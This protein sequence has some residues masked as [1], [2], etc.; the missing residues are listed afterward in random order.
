MLRLGILVGCLACSACGAKTGL[1]APPPRDAGD[2]SDDP[3]ADPPSEADAEAGPLCV[4][5]TLSFAR[6][7]D[8]AVVFV[9][10]ASGSMAE[11][12]G[13]AGSKW[14]AA[15]D[16]I[17][18]LVARFAAGVRFGLMIFPDSVGFNACAP[19]R[20]V[21]P[22]GDATADAIR[23]ALAARSPSGGTPTSQSLPHAGVGLQA[24][25]GGGAKFL[26]LVTDGEPTCDPSEPT[27]TIDEI[28]NLAWSGYA[29][30]VVGLPGSELG[31]D[32][33]GRMAVAG[34]TARATPPPYYQVTDTDL[35]ANTLGGIIDTLSTCVFPI[36]PVGGAEGFPGWVQ[37]VRFAGEPV[38]QS[39]DHTNG[40][41]VDSP[42]RPH[43][44]TLYGPWCDRMRA[45][46]PTDRLEIDLLCDA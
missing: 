43:Q 21:V 10:D 3:P 34:T 11:S 19:G 35:L 15:S 44:L 28:R 20:M 33:L 38:P 46:G 5:G 25:G 27:P 32:A 7:P 23:A 12:G 45:A 24:A 22:V 42:A 29:T 37:T 39:A 6:P 14:Q 13:G 18:T 26:I 4:P 16:A 30:Y 2:L 31:A 9:A 41:D 40:W 8:P 1:R 17:N 36:A